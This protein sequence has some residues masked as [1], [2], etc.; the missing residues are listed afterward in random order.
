[1]L[2][3]GQLGP[4]I[5]API[6]CAICLAILFSG[7]Y[8]VVERVSM[9]LVGLFSLS[10]IV[11]AVM[12]QWT[13]YAVSWSQL[14]QGFRFQLPR[15]GEVA[16]AGAG[17]ALAIVAIVGLSPT[18]IIYYPYWCVEKGYARF[19]GPN[20]PSDQW[21][22]RALGWIRVMQLDCYFAMLIYTATTVAFY[23]LGAAILH[24][25]GEVPERMNV[26]RTLSSM[27]TETLGPGAYWLF[28]ASAFMVLFSTL[29]V[30]IASYARL[31]PD[32]F[33]LMGV[34]SIPDDAARRKWVRRFLIITTVS[35]A[36]VSQLKAPPVLMIVT[37]VLPLGVMLPMVCFAAVYFRYRAVDRRIT[38][39]W[40]LDLWLWASVVLTVS[41]TVYAFV[42][43]L[44]S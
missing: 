34:I 38:P 13:D 32:C 39:S 40:L 1:M 19:T 43:P 7:R 18:E 29:F 23:L 44:L 24:G 14:A 11:S 31:L 41:L 16:E 9:V 22:R 36:T 8:Q 35:F 27:Y 28:I 6:V 4:R 33:N 37:G 30:S 21:K 42:K 2:A 20:E 10:I 26:V 5:W 25:R 15:A 3:V 17:M 12:I